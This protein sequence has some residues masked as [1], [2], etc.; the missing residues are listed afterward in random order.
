MVAEELGV[1]G[2]EVSNITSKCNG[3]TRYRLCHVLRAITLSC[4]NSS[5]FDRAATLRCDIGSNVPRAITFKIFYAVIK[6]YPMMQMKRS[7]I[8]I[9]L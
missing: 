7:V 2:T 1:L 8:A 4:N 3:V 5:N 6:R 9:K